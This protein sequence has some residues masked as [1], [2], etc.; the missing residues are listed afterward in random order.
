[1]PSGKVLVD[2]RARAGNPA[3]QIKN[4]IEIDLKFTLKTPL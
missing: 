4:E 3:R 2:N 1:M